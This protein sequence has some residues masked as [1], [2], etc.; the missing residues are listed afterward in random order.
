MR[1]L[2]YVLDDRRHVVR[3]VPRTPGPPLSNGCEIATLEMVTMYAPFKR[4]CSHRQPMCHCPEAATAQGPDPQSHPRPAHLHEDTA[5]DKDRGSWHCNLSECSRNSRIHDEH[6]QLCG[7]PF[8]KIHCNIHGCRA[9]GLA[10]QHHEPLPFKGT[11][12]L[13]RAASAPCE[14]R[15]R[16]VSCSL[17]RAADARPRAQPPRRPGWRLS[18]GPTR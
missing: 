7:C 16:I 12:D 1:M 2:S 10:A 4:C 9:E 8:R 18:R 17:G 5:A 15:Y 6:V 11:P 3:S 14:R 13:T